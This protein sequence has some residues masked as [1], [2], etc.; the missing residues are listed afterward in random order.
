M[1]KE[2]DGE[3]SGARPKPKDLILDITGSFGRYQ[4]WLCFIVFLSKF[5]IAFHQL[6]IIFY[7]P[8]LRYACG[9]STEELNLCPCDSP[10]YNYSIFTSTIM[11]EWNLICERK[12]LASIVQV[13]FQ[14][15]T[16]VGSLAFG[17]LSDRY[18]RRKPFIVA[19]VIQFVFGLT[20]AFLTSYVL[21][22]IFRFI[23]G[24][25]VGGTMVIGFVIIMEFI[26]PEYRETIS[27]LYQVPFNLGS[28]LLP[29]IS[30]QYRDFRDFQ[31]AISIPTAVFV[32]YFYAL[33]ETPRWLIAKNQTEKAIKV[34]TLT[35]KINKRPTDNIRTN[36][37]AY[38]AA[39]ARNKLPT[40]TTLDLF[41]TPNLRKNILAM[42]FNWVMCSY[43]YYGVAQFV[44]LLSG[45]IFINVAATSCLVTIGTFLSI[46]FMKFFGRKTILLICHFICCSCLIVLAF[47][48][49]I[50]SVICASIGVVSAFVVFVVVYLYCGE[51]FPTVVRNAAV[52]FS[53]MCARIGSMIAPLVVDLKD[54]QPWLAPLAFAV[55]PFLAFFITM[56]LPE[57]KGCEL[58]TTIEEGE[59]FGK[60]TKTTP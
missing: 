18:G 28:V 38:A 16:L 47:S 53:S 15:G 52:G 3:V 40:G 39:A 57:T 58:T 37:E 59:A 5:A 20:G 25:S 34:L 60:K 2:N 49:G 27:A 9:D 26:G 35:A 14:G 30:Y 46:P 41:R 24:L 55:V 21:F 51:L 33:P 36:V 13:T 31:L 54:I 1:D 11:T 42:S 45:N 12:S 10:K 7:A 23:V 8:P 29:L 4:I 43:C 19:C 22:T 50:A 48:E 6:A 32:I 44:G 17:A 56:L